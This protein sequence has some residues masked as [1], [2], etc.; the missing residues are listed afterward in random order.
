MKNSQF[1]DSQDGGKTEMVKLEMRE[2]MMTGASEE[3]A[4]AKVSSKWI[5][6]PG[7]RL[8]IHL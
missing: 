1:G 3:D 7:L 4:M 6:K 8:C 5:L 2:E